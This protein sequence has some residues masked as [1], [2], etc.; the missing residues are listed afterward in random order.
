MLKARNSV[1]KIN[2]SK[3]IQCVIYEKELIKDI[4]NLKK[5]LENIQKECPLHSV[6]KTLFNRILFYIL[7]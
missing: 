2:T 6:G 4:D 5:S 1:N 7:N 3:T